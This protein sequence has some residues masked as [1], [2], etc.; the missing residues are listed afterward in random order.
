MTNIQPIYTSRD[1]TRVGAIQ[2]LSETVNSLNH[3]VTALTSGNYA[4]DT[5][6]YIQA[7]I[8]ESQT[9]LDALKAAA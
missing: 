1:Y 2:C 5:L 6:D 7:S 4:G 9:H 3:L 8:T